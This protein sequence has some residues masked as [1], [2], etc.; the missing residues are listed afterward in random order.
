MFLRGRSWSNT[1]EDNEALALV[2]E[3]KEHAGKK[4]EEEEEK[5]KRGGMSEAAGTR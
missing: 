4:E 2:S 5:R 3:R 1:S